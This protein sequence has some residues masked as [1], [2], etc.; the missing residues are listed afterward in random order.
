MFNKEKI[1]N[2]EKKITKLE[3]ENGL[4]KTLIRTFILRLYKASKIPNARV[5]KKY[6]YENG[7]VNKKGQIRK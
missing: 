6:L 2:L 7:W 4:Q 5:I 1:K 3:L